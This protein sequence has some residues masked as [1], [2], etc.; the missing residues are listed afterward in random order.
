[1]KKSFFLI[2]LLISLTIEVK[3]LDYPQNLKTFLKMKYP[4]TVFKIDNSFVYNNQIYLPLVPLNTK[5]VKKLEIIY[6]VQ[7]ANKNPSRF[8]LLSN[9][10]AYVRLLKQKDETFTILNTAEVSPEYRN[11][12]QS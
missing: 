12:F 1:M 9:G 10:W 4:K 8:F 6:S 5:S 11:E 3:A 2:L 7:D